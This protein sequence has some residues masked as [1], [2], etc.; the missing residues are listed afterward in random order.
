[1]LGAVGT[2]DN[3]LSTNAEYQGWAQATESDRPVRV[4]GDV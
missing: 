2:G 3:A 4:N 1:M